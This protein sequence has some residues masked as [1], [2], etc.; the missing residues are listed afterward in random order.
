MSY[1]VRFEVEPPAEPRDRLRALLRPLLAIPHLLLVGGPALGLL[2][3]GYRAGG[4]GALAILI[5]VFDWVAILVTGQ[6][7]AGLRPYKRLYLT[8][9]ARVLAYASFLR[10]EYPPFGEGPYPVTFVLPEAPAARDRVNILLRPLMA[11]PH[12]V[13]LTVL[14]I[15]WAVVMVVSWLWLSVTGRMPA[16]L[17]RF[18]RDV[19][20]YSLRVEAYFL[21]LQDQFPPFALGEEAGHPLG[22][23]PV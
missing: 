4:L 9:R 15:A 3:G 7:I 10:D 8:W 11:L 18:A 16:S 14:L 17:W 1:P 20:A 6:P 5:A 23:R 21:L 12:L 2:G 22:E 19:S 13:V